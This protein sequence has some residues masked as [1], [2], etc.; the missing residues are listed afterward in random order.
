VGT[1]QPFHADSVHFRSVPERFM[2][3]VWVAL[4]EIDDDNGP[5]EHF[6]GPHRLPIYVN[7]HIGAC[8]QTRAA[9]GVHCADF[10]P[11]ARTR[12]YTEIKM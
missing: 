5:L 9:P 3:G 12:Q 2:C 1:H 4:E 7:E 6:A 11:L 10:L 8:P